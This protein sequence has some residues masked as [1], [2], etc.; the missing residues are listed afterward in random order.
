MCKHVLYISGD[1][2]TFNPTWISNNV[3]RILNLQTT[4]KPKYYVVFK[5]HGKPKHG[6]KR[7]SIKL[8]VQFWFF[9]L[10]KLK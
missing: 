10:G 3:E 7:P 6:R 5:N 9:A 4:F 2:K 8:N 1:I